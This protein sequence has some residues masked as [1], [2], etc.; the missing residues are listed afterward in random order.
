MSEILPDKKPKEFWT[1]LS[2]LQRKMKLVPSGKR[3]QLS[4]KSVQQALENLPRL[5]GSG[6]RI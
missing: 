3:E 1:G 2:P 5:D 6:K 4:T